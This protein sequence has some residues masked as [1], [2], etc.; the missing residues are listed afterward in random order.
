MIAK[1]TQFST[2]LEANN[3]KFQTAAQEACYEKVVTW[4]QE[5]FGKCPCARQDIPGLGVFMGSALVEVLIFPWDE[6]DAVINTRSYVVVGA[7]LTPDLIRYL[8][9]ENAKMIFGAFGISPDNEILFEHSIVGSTCDIKELEASVKAVME[10]ADE[11]DD[12]IVQRW[13]GKRA[14]DRIHAGKLSI[15]GWSL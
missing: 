13:G 6:D 12:K 9:E 5:I 8:L 10:I 1:L 11:Y 2:L 4:M 15:N 7:A 14:L 3:L